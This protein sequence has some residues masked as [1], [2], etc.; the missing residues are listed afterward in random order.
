MKELLVEVQI[1]LKRV[2]V[3]PFAFLFYDI[4][5][6]YSKIS[7]SSFLFQEVEGRVLVVRPPS[8]EDPVKQEGFSERKSLFQW[9]GDPGGLR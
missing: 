1:I 7:S 3:L 5:Q 9:S 8:G 2:Q 6:F 4:S